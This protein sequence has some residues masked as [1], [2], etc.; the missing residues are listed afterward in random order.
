M[1]EKDR[2]AYLDAYYENEYSA[3]KHMTYVLL[4]SAIIMTLIWVGYL[5]GLFTTTNTTRI[6]VNI[7]FPSSILIFLT[8][9]ILIRTKYLKNPKYKYFLMISFLFVIGTINVV[10]PKHG[11]LGWAIAIFLSNHYYNPKLG[12]TIFIISII[13]MLACIFGGMFLG[14]YDSNLLMGELEEK[15]A[16][17]HTFF[18]ASKVF[19]DTPV[20]RAEYLNFLLTHNQNRYLTTV[21]FY[22]MPRAA[23]IAVLFFIS[24][25]L[26]KRTYRLLIDEIKVNSDQ[27]KVATELNIA[28]EIQLSSLPN[29][30]VTSQDIELVAELKATREVGGDFYYYT[31][32]D[33]EHTVVVVGD[34][35]G[36]GV[37]AA[38]FMMK[39]ITCFKNLV[40]IDKKPSEILREVNATLFEGNDNQMFVTCFLAIVNN[41][42]GVV[43]FANAGHI[44]PAIGHNRA[45]HPLK[46]N[47]GFVLGSLETCFVKDESFVLNN[48][49]SMIL[50]TDGITESR[51]EKGEFFGEY[52]L[53]K[54]LNLRDYSTLLDLHRNLKDDVLSF[55]GNAIQADDIT[56]LSLKYHG[57]KYDFEEKQFDSNIEN[58]PE[59]QGFIRE[60]ATK[61]NVD[62]ITKHKLLIVADEL[63]S[64][65]VKYAYGDSTGEI[66]IRLLFN[67]KKNEFAMTLID[68]GVAFNP[69]KKEEKVLVDGTE[70][71]GGLGLTI[72]KETMNE[73]AYD[74]INNKNIVTLKKR[75]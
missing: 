17:I 55:V 75:I 74:R 40:R 29:N 20:G 35:S 59:M 1:D 60:F 73:L 72:V 67:I 15:T 11:I 24:N 65:I 6:I 69:F 25:S 38:M 49:D 61:H 45:Y 68:R 46:C 7:V 5:A 22:F 47:T 52:R 51:N 64:N 12:R 9:L 57:D 30:I 56:V 50:Y 13:G 48:G 3:N 27:E 71:E 4:F 39:T 36:K 19:E 44:P 10:L 23:F 54:Q 58:M 42:T 37:P 2:Q 53:Y 63:L 33:D 41:K 66:F 62:E 32:L 70:K 43:D 34:V 14:E 31:N 21:I 26:N 16:T 18:D 28:K 8:P